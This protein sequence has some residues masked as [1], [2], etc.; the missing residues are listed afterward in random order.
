MLS[1]YVLKFSFFFSDMS[2]EYKNFYHMDYIDVEKGEVMYL[3]S[4]K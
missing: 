3:K 4:L 1:L 2:D